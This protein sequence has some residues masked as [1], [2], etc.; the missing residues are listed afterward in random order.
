MSD[1]T[2]K[3]LWSDFISSGIS[4]EDL[5]LT[6]AK[7]SRASGAEVLSEIAKSN[8]FI[9][10]GSGDLAASTKQLVGDT[11]FTKDNPLGRNIE[12][13]VRE[14]AMAG[15]TNGIV[16]HSNLKAFASTFLVFSDYMLSLMHI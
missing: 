16:L 2:F 8:E 3:G 7:A 11:Y 1:N 9:L 12:Y 5:E 15:I 6:E 13:G 14:H 4:F 10:G